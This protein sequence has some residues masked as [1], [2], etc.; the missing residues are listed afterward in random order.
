[1]PIAR[2]IA[3]PCRIKEQPA[4]R[5]LLNEVFI[6]ERGARVLQD[7]AAGAAKPCRVLR[8]VSRTRFAPASEVAPMKVLAIMG[9]PRKGDTYHLTQRVE[10]KMRALGEYEFEY[11]WLRDL[12]LGFCHGC[13]GCLWRGDEACPHHDVVVE[14][15]RRLLAADGVVFAS[16]V[17]ALDMTALLKNLLDHL[18]HHMHRPCFFDQRVLLVCTAGAMGVG[19]ALRTM[20]AV[21]VM[22]FTVAHKLGMLM[23]SE[24]RTHA[25]ERLIERKAERAAQAFHRALHAP[26][27]S[28]SLMDLI[29]FRAQ[30]VFFR[31]NRDQVPADHEYF[32][33]R[34]WFNPQRKYYVDMPVNPLKDLVARFVGRASAWQTRRRLATP[35]RVASGMS[36]PPQ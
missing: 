13:Y 2:L 21:G 10:E 33:E 32:A 1:M 16:P 30:Q 12:D 4:L 11:L 14:V 9:S 17:Y 19:I 24:Q 22:G 8:S 23:Q 20:P 31:L 34:G 27:P 6:S 7:H 36:G 25:E 26:R 29:T 35:A 15:E 28:P 18:A 3:G 5:R